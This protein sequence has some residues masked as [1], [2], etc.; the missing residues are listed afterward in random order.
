MFLLVTKGP[1]RDTLSTDVP[2]INGI[3]DHECL[4]ATLRGEPCRQ[5]RYFGLTDVLTP[6]LQEPGEMTTPP[7]AAKRKAVGF[8]GIAQEVIEKPVEVNARPQPHLQLN[9][10]LLKLTDMLLF[11]Q[12]FTHF[13]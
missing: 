7:T 6:K 9:A 3:T 10:E 1:A 2:R 11:P 8:H 4:D 13:K 5:H 12:T